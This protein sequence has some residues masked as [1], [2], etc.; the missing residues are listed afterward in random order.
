MEIV[1]NFKKSRKY[2]EYIKT[3]VSLIKFKNMKKITFSLMFVLIGLFANSQTTSIKR[4]SGSAK[5]TND[6]TK[7][8]TEKPTSIPNKDPKLIGNNIRR[9]YYLNGRDTI[10]KMDT[11]SVYKF[12]Y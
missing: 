3:L 9:V 6:T 4:G 2:L 5:N 10:Y 8:K 12:D 7:Q 1:N 11:L